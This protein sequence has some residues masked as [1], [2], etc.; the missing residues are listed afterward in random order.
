M[1]A[2]AAVV[3]AVLAGAFFSTLAQLPNLSLVFLMAVLFSAASF[4]IWPGIYASGLSVLAYNFFFLDPLYTLE[5]GKAHELFALVVFLIVAGVTSA[6]A[7]RVRDQAQAAYQR[8]HAMR[9]LYEFT[10]KLS[11]LTSVDAI[12]DGAAGEIYTSLR[13][14]AAILL[15]Q[16]NDV[17]LSACWP[18]DHD[19]DDVSMSAARLAFARNEP[20]GFGTNILPD[21]RWHFFPLRTRRSP[22]GVVGIARNPDDP[23]LEPE[24]RT[25]LASL[26]EQTAAAVDRAWLAGEISA[27]QSSAETERV[28]NVLLS[29]VSHDFR[30]PLAAITGSVT[31]LIEHAD[32][33]DADASTALLHNIKTEAEGLDVMVRNLLAITRID[34]GALELRRDAIDLREIIER[35]ISFTKR[36]GTELQFAVE[37]APD[38]PMIDADA[39]LVEQALSNVINNAVMHTPDGTRVTVD[40]VVLPASVAVRISDDG[41]GIPKDFLPHVFEKFVQRGVGHGTGLGLAIAAG[42]IAAHGGSVAAESPVTNGRGSR[43]ILTFPR[44]RSDEQ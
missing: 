26:A 29:S 37:L 17:S 8:A 14:P 1:W 36:R 16:G 19:L 34:A 38:L 12:T 6:L 28:R 44:G 40:A 10:G 24:S 3:V 20:V 13:R 39:T 27:A 33:L 4:G 21:L 30:T 11:G 41:P 25:L 9:R 42:I 23:A 18:P 15:V 43:I 5:V 22:V 2:T 32:R 35:V 31:S 7:G